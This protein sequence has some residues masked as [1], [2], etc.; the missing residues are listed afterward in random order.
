MNKLE[1]GHEVVIVRDDGLPI[2][3]TARVTR[4]DRGVAY[5]A[6][7]YLMCEPDERGAY[8][9]AD[10]LPWVTGWPVGSDTARVAL[11]NVARVNDLIDSASTCRTC[12]GIGYVY[13]PPATPRE[14]RED[15]PVE[16]DCPRCGGTGTIHTTRARA[17]VAKERT[18]H[19]AQDPSPDWH[20][21]V[22]DL[23]PRWTP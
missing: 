4:T 8:P 15:G 5:A 19:A 20:A 23:A 9:S 1:K 3:E 10:G 11:A 2:G 12:D 16:N 17:I 7:R 18:P 13:R 6:G 21:P 14:R 22:A